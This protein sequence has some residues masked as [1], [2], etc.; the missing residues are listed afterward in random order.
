[1]KNSDYASEVILGEKYLDEQSG[2]E[3]VATSVHFYQYACERVTIELMTRDGVLQEATFDSPRLTHC[4]SGKK[5]SIKK[6]G[7]PARA[8]ESRMVPGQRT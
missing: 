3:G 4:A 1:M 8:G 7:G 6:T 2:I 5:V